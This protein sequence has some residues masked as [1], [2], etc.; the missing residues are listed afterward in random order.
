M[1][2]NNLCLRIG[3]YVEE[4]HIPLHKLPTIDIPASSSK[5]K[6]AI[7]TSELLKLLR[8]V[9]G[10]VLKSDNNDEQV[11]AMQDLSLDEQVTMKNVVEDVLANFPSPE[12]AHFSENNEKNSDANQYRQELN[13]LRRDLARANERVSQYHE[14]LGHIESEFERAT[15][16]N[17]ELASQLA[18]FRSLEQERNTMRDLLDEYKPMIDA[19]KKQ[20][21]TLGKLR[22]RAEETLELKR[23]VKELETKNAELVEQ[24][25]DAVDRS[26][27]DFAGKQ[28]AVSLKSDRKYAQLEDQHA[29]LVKE[30]NVLQAQFALLEDKRHQDQIQLQSLLERVRSLEVDDTHHRDTLPDALRSSVSQV[31]HTQDPLPITR[32]VEKSHDAQLLGQVQSAQ[33][34]SRQNVGYGTLDLGT[35]LAAVQADITAMRNN[36]TS[37]RSEIEHLLRKLE[38]KWPKDA[39]KSSTKDIKN[40]S[41]LLADSF[42]H[43]NLVLE[44]LQHCWDQANTVS[45]ISHPFK[46]TCTCV[47]SSALT[48]SNLTDYT[49]SRPVHSDDD[50]RRGMPIHVTYAART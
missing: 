38:K 45:T 9:L 30:R 34:S 18:S 21:R 44:R 14:Q 26:A 33:H 49:R 50:R 10:I 25:S 2:Q 5:K 24:A 6:Q 32:N 36:N 12:D 22:E 8:L 15:T 31:E 23:Q 4:L 3:S 35:T 42:Q 13:A 29:E 41:N 37:R 16:E 19:Y 46:C 40:V 48:F 17:K 47:G 7:A 27:S 20:E 43:E 28:R 1:F 39:G 11:R